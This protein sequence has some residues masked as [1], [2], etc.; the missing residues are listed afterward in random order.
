VK[1]NDRNTFGVH[2]MTQWI[3]QVF[4]ARIGGRPL[5]L[6]FDYDGTLTPLVERPRQAILSETTRGS[7]ESLARQEGIQLGILSGR[8][9]GSLKELVGLS[10]L[11][12]AG[13]NGM[14]I[15]FGGE[16]RVDRSLFEFEPIVDSLHMALTGT[17]QFFPGTWIERKPGCLTL[18]F[19]S[20]QPLMGACF[21]EEVRDTLAELQ[22]DCPPLRIKE[23]SKAVEVSLAASWTKGDAVEWLL[24][25]YPKEAYVVFAC[26]GSNDEEAVS[27][28]NVRG[29]LTL[30][31]GPEPPL[32]VAMRV[33]TARDFVADLAELAGKTAIRGF[34]D[35]R[36]VARFHNPT[37]PSVR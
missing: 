4:A 28:V 35:E 20:L 24:S 9:L 36:P 1:R 19:R 27:L 29:G 34:G 15:E 10:N 8:A 3:D 2:S 6:L 5:V 13:S 16:E 37:S 17:I 23:V 32:G 14:H 21:V 26:D 22:S 25:R 31:V 12:Y 11:V 33:A 18:H 7:L 30:G